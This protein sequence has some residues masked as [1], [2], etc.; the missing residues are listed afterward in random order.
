M[1]DTY[2]RKKAKNA[3]FYYNDYSKPIS[4]SSTTKSNNEVS[5]GGMINKSA[6]SENIT[7][8][9]R[10]RRSMS[11]PRLKYPENIEDRS[12]TPASMSFSLYEVD[13]YKV[14]PES[15][16]KYFDI[17]LLTG[18][19]SELSS[20]ISN[21]VGSN[22]MTAVEQAAGA[23]AYTSNVGGTG[24]YTAYEPSSAATNKADLDN[25]VAARDAQAAADAM[26]GNSS[27][28]KVLPLKNA[29]TVQLYMPPS[30]QVNDD[31][32][33]SQ[34]DLGSGGLVATAALNNSAS[35]V[36]A[37]SKGLFEGVENIF[38]LARGSLNAEAAQVAATRIQQKIPSAGLRA[39]SATAMQVG[40]NPGSR[41]LFEKPNMRQFTFTFRMIATSA[42]EAKQIEEI[43]KHFRTY[44]YPET[45]NIRNVPIGYKFPPLFKIDFEYRGANLKVPSILYS[46]LKSAQVVYNSQTGTFH[47]DGQ[48]TEVDLTLIFLEY[49]ALSRDDIKGGY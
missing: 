49:R 25:A 13:S 23:G 33:Y 14:D 28:L 8:S 27:D 21:E 9:Y 11:N 48:P 37:L 30:L 22:G 24:D 41:N 7:R 39:A 43:V 46:Y 36:G 40:L 35:I 26:V 42:S 6:I 4:N 1:T 3:N 29:P 12:A 45:I 17:P 44:M 15:L 5:L 2:E 32:A 16:S 18:K 20:S 31:I 47:E 38:N 10:G 34:V 19:K